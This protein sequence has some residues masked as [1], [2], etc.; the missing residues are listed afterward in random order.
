MSGPTTFAPLIKKAVEIEKQMGGKQLLVLVMIT[1]GTVSNYRLD[2]EAM[3]EASNYPISLCAIGVGDG[4]F[5]TMNSLTT[6][7]ESRR[8]DNFH[9]V[10]FTALEK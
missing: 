7:K 9:F 4:P 6:F 8:F 2:K 3:T 10:D 5:I 1:D